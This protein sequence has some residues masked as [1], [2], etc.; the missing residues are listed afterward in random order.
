[1]AVI[2]QTPI[3]SQIANGATTVFPFGFLVVQATDLVVKVIDTSGSPTTK[4]LGVDYTVAGLG[5]E[6]G[7]AVTFLAAPAN[8]S[9]V[10]IYRDSQLARATDY[11]T[12]GDF[13]AST[14]N[15][16]FDRIWLALQEI[17]SGGKGSPTSVR[18]PNGEVLSEMPPGAS[19][20]GLLLGF[21][22][23]GNPIAVVA[24]AGTASDVLLQLANGA[25]PS[26][27]D[28]LLGVK[29][30]LAGAVARTQHQKNADLVSLGDFGGV[31]D[32]ATNNDA[33]VVAAEAV[34]DDIWLPPGTFKVSD[35]KAFAKRYWGPG[36]FS[37][38]GTGA[39]T[40]TG[41]G[42][43]DL[44]V[45]GTYAGSIPMTILVKIAS[46]GSPDTWQF[47]VDGGSTWVTQ[48]VVVNM[49]DS[50]TITPLMVSTTP[51][52]IGHTG[53]SVAWGATTG[54][55]INAQWSFSLQPNAHIVNAQTMFT[56]QGQRFA[57][58]DQNR[59]VG[60]GQN[61]M[62]AGHQAS[63]ENVGVGVDV[64]EQLTIGYGNTGV[65]VRSAQMTKDG[66]LNTAIGTWALRENVS[67]YNNCSI[68][69]YT[70]VFSLNGY[71]NTACGQ[72]ALGFPGNGYQNTAV[73]CQAMHGNDEVKLGFTPVRNTSVG[74][75]SMENIENGQ[76][77]TA[78]GFGA[79]F[80]LTN[81]GSNTAVGYSSLINCT[82]D[83]NVAVGVNAGNPLTTGTLNTFVGPGAGNP[84]TQKVDAVNTIA[85]GKDAFTTADNQI[86]I[87]NSS[88]T[89][90]FTW[91]PIKPQNDNAQ[92]LGGPGARWSQLYAGTTTI[93]TSD[94]TQKEQIE[95][96]PDALLDAW[97]DVQWQ[98]FKF[99]D[100]VA[101]KGAAAR[102]H[103]GLIAQRVRDAFEARGLDAF[104]LGLLCYDEWPEESVNGHV[105]RPAGSAYGVR[106]D[107]AFAMEAALMRR[108]LQRLAARVPA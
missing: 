108:E 6:A 5:L 27:G 102:W 23:S 1:M 105:V 24:G 83:N 21:D 98:R 67:G 64:L 20:A 88:H 29:S 81:A 51:F 16:D 82:G 35:T 90:F 95:D 85:I 107:E 13:P 66:F 73:G 75:E 57:W 22:G 26:K 59:T 65:G 9:R 15:L 32:G 89:G 4:A 49:D 96:I 70:M 14:V 94:E 87:G 43:N 45:S 11:Q 28:A 79:L 19:R 76:Y 37:F 31:G 86:V 99:K 8:G 34:A 101:R 40:F 62:G 68:G 58:A 36:R 48:N 54:H 2:E 93:N 38:T 92:T 71:A 46:S 60:L 30:A 42:L 80:A 47:S 69:A 52:P 61:V 44:V 63:F 97:G 56:I 41:T 74:C 55:A 39:R 53:I 12:Q 50:E 77:N 72:D 100:S 78:I 104:E 84:V 103:T 106:Y 18:A 17:F 91:A 25:D 3:G 7:G 33:A 10:V